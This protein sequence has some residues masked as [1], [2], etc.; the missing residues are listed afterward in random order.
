MTDT[1]HSTPSAAAPATGTRCRQRVA[2]RPGDR[3]RRARRQR[4][5]ARPA[6]P[7]PQPGDVR[8]AGRQR[9]DDDPVL[10]RPRRLDREGERLRRARRRCSCGSPCCSPTS[11]RRWPRAAARRR[12]R[13]CARPGPR[14]MAR[15][16]AARRRRSRRSRAASSQVGDVCV[17]TAGEVIPSDGDVVEGIATRRR[18]GDH[19][20]VGAGH[21]R[22]RR[23]PLGGHR[24]HPRAVRRDRRAHHGPSRARR[25]STA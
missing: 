11:P 2:V 4:P 12:P 16:P 15:P 22:V 25:S 3:P 21:P 18:V 1:D 8:R 7:G 14:R 5:Q 20:R 13:R 17:V 24:R 9:A 6:R 23:R 19:R 10:P